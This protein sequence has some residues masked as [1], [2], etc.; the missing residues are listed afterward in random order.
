MIIP[1]P[2]KP[3]PSLA[4]TEVACLRLAVR[5]ARLV[6]QAAQLASLIRARSPEALTAEHFTADADEFAKAIE[7][8]DG[9]LRQA[10]L[11]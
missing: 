8:V 10:E 4:L 11:A 5:E 3:E 1:F 6:L 2:A 7:R 9:L